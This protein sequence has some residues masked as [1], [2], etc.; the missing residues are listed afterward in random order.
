MEYT[1]T[2]SRVDVPGG[3]LEATRIVKHGDRDFITWALEFGETLLFLHD[4]R[5]WN[6]HLRQVLKYPAQSQHKVR[7]GGYVI[8]TEAKRLQPAEEPAGIVMT[9][10]TG[11]E[12]PTSLAA[13]IAAGWSQVGKVGRR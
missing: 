10:P 8:T 13:A 4:V 12:P 2:L 7:I 11:A 3:G 5:D 9:A 1:T 6:H